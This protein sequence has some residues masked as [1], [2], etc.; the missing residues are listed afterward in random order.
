MQCYPPELKSKIVKNLASSFCKVD[1][2]DLAHKP[3]KKKKK[4]PSESST[5]RQTGGQQNKKNK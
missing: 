4:E 5:A 3:A 1:E 2:K